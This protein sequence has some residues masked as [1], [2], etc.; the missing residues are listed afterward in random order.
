[1]DT[2]DQIDKLR[3]DLQDLTDEVY[4]N[5]FSSHQ[6]FNKISHFNSKLKIPVVSS[7]PAQ[8]ELGEILSY[9]GKLYIASA[10]NTW[11]IAGTQS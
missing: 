9:S 10:V 4:R 7:L 1:M 11:T 6:D 8:C 2:Q 3:R 5:N